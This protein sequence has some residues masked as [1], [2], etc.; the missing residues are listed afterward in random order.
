MAPK[1]KKSKSRR[2]QRR[3]R[4]DE[5]VAAWHFFHV[6]RPGVVQR[7]ASLADYHPGSSDAMTIDFLRDEG[8]HHPKRSQAT[9]PNEYYTMYIAD[10][11]Q[12]MEKRFGDDRKVRAFLK[13]RFQ[14]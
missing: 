3:R 11:L 7:P 12:R 14:L 13:R 5:R 8:P 2:S 10:A 1:S 6:D 9:S 4:D